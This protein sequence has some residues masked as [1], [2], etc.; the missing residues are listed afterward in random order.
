M[1][2]AGNVAS[3][4]SLLPHT[5]SLIGRVSNTLLPPH[6]V[7]ASTLRTAACGGL[8]RTSAPARHSR[9]TGGL[10]APERSAAGVGCARLGVWYDC[11][12]AF[13]DGSFGARP[14]RRVRTPARL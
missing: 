1:Q 12:Y 9:G 13:E 2:S 7:R 4:C 6:N 5:I 14:G 8:R 10:A 11:Q 3:T